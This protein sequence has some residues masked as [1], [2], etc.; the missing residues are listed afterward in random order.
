MEKIYILR[1]ER[2]MLDGKR[3]KQRAIKYMKEFVENKDSSFLGEK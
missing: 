2:I 1:K 3:R